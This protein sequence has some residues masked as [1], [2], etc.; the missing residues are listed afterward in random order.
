MSAECPLEKTED[1]LKVRIDWD[2]RRVRHD[3][4][5]L[6]FLVLFWIIWAP[7]TV[8]ATSMIFL[9]EAIGYWLHP[10]VKEKIFCDL[11][12]F[13]SRRKLPIAFQR[14]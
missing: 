12:E 5:L 7:V 3:K 6:W 9:S 11:E 14:Y 2:N 8:F 13:A 1:A 4:F 10:S